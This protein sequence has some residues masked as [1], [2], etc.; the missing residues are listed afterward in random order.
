MNSNTTPSSKPQRVI[1][2]LAQMLIDGD[3]QP[4]FVKR[5]AEEVLKECHA[6]M[7][8]SVV[9]EELFSDIWEERRPSTLPEA[10][11]EASKLPVWERPSN[12]TELARWVKVRLYGH[13]SLAASSMKEFLVEFGLE[14]LQSESAHQPAVT[15]SEEKGNSGTKDTVAALAAENETTSDENTRYKLIEQLNRLIPEVGGLWLMHH[16]SGQSVPVI[17]AVSGMSQESVQEELEIASAWLLQHEQE[18]PMRVRGS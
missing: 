16:S 18:Q 2:P 1:D 15:P 3:K 17:A 14:L 9:D 5:D 6:R 12:R 4:D 7:D 13:A 10:L 8:A 11:L